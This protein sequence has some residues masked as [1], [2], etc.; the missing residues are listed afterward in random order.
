MFHESYDPYPKD[1]R[2]CV[3]SVGQTVFDSEAAGAAG[4]L[5]PEWSF[6][7]FGDLRALL[8]TRNIYDHGKVKFDELK[9]YVAHAQHRSGVLSYEARCGILGRYQQ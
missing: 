8:E 7:F 3:L 2:L 6:H 4:R 9:P 1:G 5:F